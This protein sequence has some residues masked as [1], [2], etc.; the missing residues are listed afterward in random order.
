ALFVIERGLPSARGLEGDTKE[1]ALAERAKV[2][3]E[4]SKP[5]VERELELG[6]RG[7]ARD[8]A[9]AQ[10][11]VAREHPEVAEHVEARRRHERAEAGEELVRGHVGVGD[12]A[13]RNNPSLAR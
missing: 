3:R 2:R 6:R 12:A 8:D 5:R 4:V 10:V 13:A 11:V 1:A 9:G 7:G